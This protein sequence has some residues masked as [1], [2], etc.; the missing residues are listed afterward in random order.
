MKTPRK[1]GSAGTIAAALASG[2]A[3]APGALRT[4][5]FVRAARAFGPGRTLEPLRGF[6]WILLL[7]ALSL[8]VAGP[9]AAQHGERVMVGENIFVGANESLREVVCIGCS[10]RVEGRTE[11]VV[12]IGGSI[13]IAGS[14]REAVAIGGNVEV[15]G[16]TEREVVAV[17]GNVTISGSVGREVVAVF[18]DVILL[19]GASVEQDVVSVG[20][21][22]Q[23]VD[24]AKI[25]G[26]V[27]SVK[28]F[29][30]A[31]RF[32]FLMFLAIFLIAGLVLQP[33]FAVLC[34]AILG[35]RRVWVLAET[36]RSRAGLCFVL[37]LGLLFGSFMLSIFG[38]IN[39]FLAPL[40]SFPFWMLF[41][42]LLVVG[43]TGISYWVGRSLVSTA[44]AMAA[45]LL[46]AVLVTILQLIP[47]LGWMAFFVFSLM[48]MGAALL[49]G[50]GTATDWLI[51]RNSVDPFARPV[52][53]T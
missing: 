13:E 35:E 6:G 16:Q 41:F 39:P 48:A 14:V 46:G 45:T 20:G 4:L 17:G 38:A 23:G 50:F 27:Q 21:R 49:S 43:Y 7:A 30:P 37:G 18:G 28:P 33:L 36:A 10:I 2:P 51:K 26:S 3:W 42:V 5:G 1:F 52:E 53:R 29:L 24:R 11:E 47:I 31:L 40:L 9:L 34:H 19:D 22:V 12:A 32:G 8:C 15:T 25:G 44:G